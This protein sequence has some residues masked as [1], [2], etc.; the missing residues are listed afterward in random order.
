MCAKKATGASLSLFLCSKNVSHQEF[1]YVNE[2]APFFLCDNGTWLRYVTRQ[3]VKR[4]ANSMSE[5]RF[6]NGVMHAKCLGC[7]QAQHAS[8]DGDRWGA[9]I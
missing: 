7:Y 3:D 2:S 5:D 8:N 1:V 4:F 6:D 9:W